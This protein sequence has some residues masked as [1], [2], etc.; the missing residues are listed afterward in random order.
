MEAELTQ[1]LATLYRSCRP[2]VRVVDMTMSSKAVL[3]WLGTKS[4]GERLEWGM[5]KLNLDYKLDI[6][7]DD[8][9]GSLRRSPPDAATE[10][11][12]LA[13]RSL[14]ERGDDSVSHMG[15]EGGVNQ[16][17]E[18]AEI[19]QGAVPECGTSYCAEQ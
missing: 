7:Q 13:D 9:V 10:C 19:M 3:G 5:R 16:C 14:R 12:A 1:R 2:R 17:S 15:G 11:T 18:E 8:L 6:S 4:V